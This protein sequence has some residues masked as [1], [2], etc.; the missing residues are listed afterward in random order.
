MFRNTVHPWV[1]ATADIDVK[2]GAKEGHLCAYINDA[3]HEHNVTI[4]NTDMMHVPCDCLFRYVEGRYKGT[5]GRPD[6]TS[7]VASHMQAHKKEDA[8]SR[9]SFLSSF[10]SCAESCAHTDHRRQLGCALQ[11]TLS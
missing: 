10:R 5:K 9:C 6:R 4:G 11:L 2:A 7:V 8:S 3:I 1:G